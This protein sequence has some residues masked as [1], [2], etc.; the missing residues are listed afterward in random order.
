MVWVETRVSQYYI[1]ILQYCL[2]VFIFFGAFSVIWV[3]LKLVYPQIWWLKI[4]ST[5]KLTRF[6]TYTPHPTWRQTHIKL[7]SHLA[8]AQKSTSACA[9]RLRCPLPTLHCKTHIIH[10]KYHIISSPK[11]MLPAKYQL[12]SQLTNPHDLSISPLYQLFIGWFS[13][14]PLFDASIPTCHHLSCLDPPLLILQFFVW[15]FWQLPA[16]KLTTLFQLQ[17]LAGSCC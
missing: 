2:I 11:K 6:H 1:V 14:I 8:W 9:K 16:T 3:Y 7:V 4:L 13:S 5:I 17:L 10:I 15:D 12:A